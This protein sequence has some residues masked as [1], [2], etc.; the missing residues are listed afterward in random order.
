M[1]L[2]KTGPVTL[3]VAPSPW[4]SGG[5]MRVAKIAVAGPMRVAIGKLTN[6]AGQGL[7]GPTAARRPR[8]LADYWT[9]YWLWTW[10][11]VKLQV[12]AAVGS[13]LKVAWVAPAGIVM[14]WFESG[15]VQFGSE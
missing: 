11:T 3:R 10:Y 12:P 4:R 5:P 9:V 15:V 8:C 7:L 2:A 13:R 14:A 6:G 1:T